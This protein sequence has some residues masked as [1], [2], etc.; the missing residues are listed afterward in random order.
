MSNKKKPLCKIGD[1]VRISLNKHIFSKGYDPNW[2]EEVFK[3]DKIILREPIVYCL[4]DLAEEAI[5][6]V[7]YEKEV[8]KVII[9]EDTNYL[10]DKIVQTRYRNGIR[11]AYVKWRGYSDKFNSWIV[12]TKI[13]K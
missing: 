7:F 6:G 13:K 10:I 11:E 3:I 4:K 12:Y 5:E 9:N 2:S 8:Q 1:I